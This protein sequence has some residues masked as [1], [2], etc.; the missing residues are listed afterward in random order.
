MRETIIT[1]LFALLA[2]CTGPTDPSASPVPSVES[3][4]KEPR[5]EIPAEALPVPEPSPWLIKPDEKRDHATSSDVAVGQE[6]P[7]EL[8]TH[9]GIDFRV[10][11]DGSFWQSYVVGNTPTVGNPFEKG[12]MTLLSAEVAVFRFESQGDEASVYF[13]RN[14][15]PKPK[16]GCD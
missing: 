15:T 2:A 10:D 12:T 4:P 16:V 14:D 8:Y 7:F 3:T 11:F 5:I 6:R 9:C 1:V 13:I